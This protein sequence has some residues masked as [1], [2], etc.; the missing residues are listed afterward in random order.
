MDLSL[1]SR[2][3][4][5]SGHEM[6]RLGLG[7]WQAGRSETLSAVSAA[8]RLGYRLIDTAKLYGNEAEVGRAVRESGI[9]RREIFVTT[10]LWN[11]DHGAHRAPAA[12][13]ASLHRLGLEYV[14]LYLIHWPGSSERIATWRA[15]AAIAK[16]GR[17][18]S[19]GVSN[20]TVAHLE[21]LVR[22]TGVVPAVNQIEQHPRLYQKELDE[23]CAERG[24]A[25]ECYSPL[26]RGRSFRDRA[27]QSVASA[28]VRS[29]AQVMLRWGLQHGF[30]VIP[31]SVRPERI[32]E[33]ARLFDFE[34]SRAEMAQLDGLGETERVAWDPTRVT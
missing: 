15:L 16:E 22:E 3:R 12:F 4:L 8:L 25:I 34:L 27:I 24:I 9:D 33:N 1:S 6:P 2:V 32:A 19:I 31:K 21:E 10:K 14:D 30:I 13:D 23:Y 7:V 26:A 28:H 5:N 20:F 17:S 29:P 11:D 18:R